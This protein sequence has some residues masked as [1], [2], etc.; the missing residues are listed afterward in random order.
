MKR[1]VVITLCGVLAAGAL[2]MVVTRDAGRA[3]HERATYYCPM[4]PQIA[5]DRPG[6]CPI[7]HMK[8]V[9][10]ETAMKDICYLHNCPMLEP[11]KQCPM[12]V[13]AKAGE[14]VTCPVCGT[15]V[16][17][18]AVSS[19]SAPGRKKILYWTDPM[20]PG[21]RAEKPGKSPMGMDLVPVYEEAEAGPGS[22]TTPS[23]Y[24]P[25][26][27]TPQKQQ[28]IGVTTASVERRSMTKTIRAAGIVAHDPELYQTQQEYIEALAAL[29]QARVSQF[30]EVI[31]RAE[32]LVESSQLRLRH[33]GLSEEMMQ[34]VAT[35]TKP[36]HRLL[37]GG[38][39]QFWVYASIYEYELPWVTPGQAV[40]VDVSALP[41]RS[42]PGTV[43]AIDP[44]LEHMS[45]TARVRILVEDA[46]G[47]LKPAMY[48]NVSIAVDLGEVLA[49][50][51]EA[52]FRTG[53]QS[54]VFVD[55]GQG[56][57]EPREVAVGAKADDFY[58]VRAGFTE[59]ERV[60]TSGNF[61][62][63]SESRLKAALQGMGAPGGEHS[64]GH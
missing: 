45:R 18:A 15:H 57:F 37:L 41:N 46:G 23:G 36:D 26:L 55:K 10:R 39:G 21:F 58:E 13:V 54:I 47:I 25:I 24:A 50:P 44:I 32:R 49:V 4:H 3:T 64:H 9:K 53:T 48:V 17:E 7:C 62:I 61:L 12:L 38:A 60:V 63:D 1:L 29:Q 2:V 33:V 31:E 6:E 40:T 34:E 16:A 14:K 19:S 35:W 59:G 30:P 5:A 28:L 56:L 52:V 20:I 8:L 11:G 51:E 22:P 27:V 43:K 42:F